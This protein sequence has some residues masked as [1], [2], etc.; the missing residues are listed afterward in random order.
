MKDVHHEPESC[1]RNCIESTSKVDVDSI[2]SLSLS[3]GFT[4]DKM[5]F[6]HIDVDTSTLP[7]PVLPS[8]WFSHI[9]L[10]HDP[11]QPL[12]DDVIEQ[13]IPTIEQHYLFFDQ[14]FCWC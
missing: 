7:T 13:L 4:R 2:D 9:C 6:L 14:T 1:L 3:V 8:G 11:L 5:Y 12:G 10:F